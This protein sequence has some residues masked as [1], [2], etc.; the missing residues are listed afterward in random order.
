MHI[1]PHPSAVPSGAPRKPR[2]LTLCH[3]V[4]AFP[5]LSETFIAN[6]IRALRDLGHTVIPAVI[7]PDAGP[8][9]P[10]DQAL[11]EDAVRLADVETMQA[12]NHAATNPAGLAAAVDFA[13]RQRGTPR[14]ALLRAAARLAFTARTRGC[15]HI[16]AY[17]AEA[18]AVA[19]CAA[20]IAGITASFA[21]HGRQA[22]GHDG[23]LALQLAAT[24]LAIAVDAHMAAAFRRLAPQ[25]NLCTIP[26]GV[27]PDR[28]RPSPGRS[29]GRLLAIGELVPQKGFHALLIALSYLHPLLRPQVDVVGTGPLEQELVAS[30]GDLG[31]AETVNFLGPRPSGWIVT[32]GPQ[33]Q[34]MVCPDVID[35]NGVR[36]NGLIAIK[37]AMAMGLPI[38][39]S[40]LPGVRE[41]VDADCARLAPPGDVPALA[42][43]LVWLAGLEPRA[44]TSL[45]ANGRARVQ[46][47]FTLRQQAMRLAAA[48]ADLRP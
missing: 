34:G 31:L 25:A 20:R 35:Q 19:I 37:E 38:V 22:G 43:G 7:A 46:E 6:E 14:R 48:F 11:R 3:V 26:P 32:E 16:H 45:G 29:N 17:F 39:A 15:T 36:D 30:A 27:A 41:V 28:F 2:Q 33:Y 9:L 5:G 12:L 23:E 21:G 1:G 24:D 44:R 18:A 13:H 42:E 40:A 8:M 47:R 4:A 10:V